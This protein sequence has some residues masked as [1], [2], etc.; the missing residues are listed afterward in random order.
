MRVFATPVHGNKPWS[1][2]L[3][4][5]VDSGSCLDLC[6]L[7]QTSDV[8][9][10]ELRPGSPGACS[11]LSCSSVAAAL[12]FSSSRLASDPKG[13]RSLRLPNIL[14]ALASRT[15][16][17]QDRKMPGRERRGSLISLDFNLPLGPDSLAP[18][19]QAP[20]Q[21]T[22]CSLPGTFFYTKTVHGSSACL[23][24]LLDRMLL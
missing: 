24:T 14:T 20:P 19:C 15:L 8:R 18:H 3:R 22:E 5:R 21:T 1:Q 13:A 11:P 2:T 16:V 10:Q 7:T 23:C 9:P 12:P 4:T 17:L 6:L